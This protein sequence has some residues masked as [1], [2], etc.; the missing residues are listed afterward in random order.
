MT[1]II[2]E[3]YAKQ[4]T[5]LVKFPTSK[6]YEKKKYPLIYRVDTDP[7]EAWR[8]FLDSFQDLIHE[9]SPCSHTEPLVID[10]E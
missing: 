4:P 7:K 9:E 10:F 2:Y 6:I 5:V 8:S 1:V 3:P